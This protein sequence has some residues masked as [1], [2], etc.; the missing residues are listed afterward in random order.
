MR[1]GEFWWLS[2]SRPQRPFP[3]SLRQ[4]ELAKAFGAELVLFQ[5]IALP[6]Y[7]EG[8][9]SYMNAGLADRRAF[10]GRPL[11]EIS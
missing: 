8:N 2:R 5:A 7:L 3:P 4:R 6:L 11:R 1:F 10:Y 9:V